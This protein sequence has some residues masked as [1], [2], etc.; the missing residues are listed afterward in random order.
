MEKSAFGI[1]N[2]KEVFLFDGGVDGVAFANVV[3]CVVG[4]FDTGINIGVCR[5]APGVLA[6]GGAACGD[7]RGGVVFVLTFGEMAVAGVDKE[8]AF[9]TGRTFFVFSRDGITFSFL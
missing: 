8:S 7:E 2:F 5:C 3:L 1:W 6:F 9:Q 4:A